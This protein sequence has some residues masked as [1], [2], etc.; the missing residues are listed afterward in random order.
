VGILSLGLCLAILAGHMDLSIES[1]MAFSATAASFMVATGGAGQGW[2]V[3]IGF[4]LVV[5]L[6]CGLLVGLFNG[7]L[8][9]YLKINAFIVTLSTYI[10]VRG[11]G[12]VITEGQSIYGL[13]E[14]LRRVATYN[15]KGIPLLVL[16]LVSLYALFHVLLT[17]T[18]LG[19]YIYLIGGNEKAPFRAGIRV[20][21]ILLLVFALSG[22]LAAFAGWLLAAR[23]G[24]STANLGIGM[25]F[26]AFA[27][28]VIGGVSLKGGEGRLTGVFAGVLLLSSIDTAINVMA[29]PAHTMQVVRGAL[30]LLAIL[31]DS[32]KHALHKRFL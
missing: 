20:R 23:T 3:S 32:M 26:E 14:S 4:T 19:R 28:V 11:L 6:L 8:I 15:A 27:A 1:V 24:G 13:P 7:V 25:L 16:I 10:G 31:L 21:Q 5:S 30:V 18:R 9:V 12:L 29:M 2:P 22:V 17:R